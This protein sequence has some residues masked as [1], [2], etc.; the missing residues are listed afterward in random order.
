MML[1]PEVDYQDDRSEVKL[2][3]MAKFISYV[4]LYATNEACTC[5]KISNWVTDEI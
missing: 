5:A 1:L 3:E 4:N 2:N